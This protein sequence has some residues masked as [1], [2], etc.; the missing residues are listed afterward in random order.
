MLFAGFA[1]KWGMTRK[2]TTFA[3]KEPVGKK[4]S[5]KGTNQ[6]PYGR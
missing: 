2:V 6:G 3:R 1:Q 5:S 4:M